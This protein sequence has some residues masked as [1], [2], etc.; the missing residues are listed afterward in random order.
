MNGL[1]PYKRH[2]RDK[3][4]GGEKAVRPVC[5]LVTWLMSIV[6]SSMSQLKWLWLDTVGLSQMAVWE[7]QSKQWSNHLCNYFWQS[8]IL[9]W[10]YINMTL[11][12]E[13]W[14]LSVGLYH[15]ACVYLLIG[16]CACFHMACVMVSVCLCQWHHLAVFPW[17]EQNM[18]YLIKHLSVSW[19]SSSPVAIF[20]PLHWSMNLTKLWFLFPYGTQ[21]TLGR[22]CKEVSPPSISLLV[23]WLWIF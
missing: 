2:T 23:P 8:P 12:P 1:A 3:L 21:K 10:F 11:R 7:P 20:L 17:C 4:G 13:A 9:V 15:P 16:V 14:A 18:L 5:S 6:I 22:I 19:N